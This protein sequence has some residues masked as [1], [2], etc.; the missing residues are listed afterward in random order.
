MWSCSFVRESKYA[1]SEQGCAGRFHRIRLP[2]ES[3]EYRAARDALLD[4]KIA[5]RRHAEAG[6]ER[7]RRPAPPAT[8][9]SSGRSGPCSIT[10]PRVAAPIG[11]RSLLAASTAALVSAFAL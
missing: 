7:R 9:T 4:E 1:G 6:A 11:A 3:D 10:P 8:S 2:N 5:L